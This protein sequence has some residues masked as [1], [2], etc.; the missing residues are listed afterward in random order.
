MGLTAITPAQ[1]RLLTALTGRI[2]ARLAA[3]FETLSHPE[4]SN[5]GVALAERGARAAA[6]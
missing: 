6:W 2:S 4:S 3:E 1:R 5:A